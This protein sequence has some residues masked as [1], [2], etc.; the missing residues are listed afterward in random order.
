[1]CI[2][3]LRLHPAACLLSW[4]VLLVAVQFLSWL[5]LLVVAAGIGV[6]GAGVCRRWWRLVRRARW[7]LLS[8]GLILAYGT[9]G[10]ALFDLDWAPTYEG[11]VEAILHIFRLVLLLG[12]LAW[13]F[14]RATREDL[15]AGLWY[16]V[17]PLRRW[18]LGAERG[19]VRLA[20]VMDIL[21]ETPK[22]G[23]WRQLLEEPATAGTNNTTQ[24]SITAQ[25]WRMADTARVALLAAALVGMHWLP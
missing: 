18:G 21:Q 6:A 17:R 11:G 19:V 24:V 3:E 23:N 7:L 1:M 14:E 4:F 12:S 22:P 20:L 13:L 9:P 15:L 8:L 5:A 10:E 16:G 2:L 25:V